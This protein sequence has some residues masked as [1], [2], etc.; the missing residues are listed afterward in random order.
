MRIWQQST[1]GG[2]PR[3]ERRK[4]CM[5]VGKR[6]GMRAAEAGRRAVPI[7]IGM[8]HFSFGYFSFVQAK[9]K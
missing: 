8:V 1:A 5:W 7:A 6:D 2:R 4:P 9:E 3:T